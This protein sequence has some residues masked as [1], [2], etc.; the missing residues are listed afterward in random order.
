VPTL[1]QA[2]TK[3][4]GNGSTERAEERATRLLRRVGLAER[5]GHRPGQLSG[6]ERQRVA[7]VRALINRAPLLLADEPT[8]ALDHSSAE[9]LAQLLVELN[10]EERITLILVTHSRELAGKMGK[11]FELKDGHL[12]LLS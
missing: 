10:V 8:G 1:A 7:L 4:L 3:H 9:Q 11:R 12:Q 6:G 2:G 5:L